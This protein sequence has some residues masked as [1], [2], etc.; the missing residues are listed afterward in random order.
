MSINKKHAPLTCMTPVLPMCE[1][2]TLTLSILDF[3]PE[4]FA[5]KIT[6]S[7][8]DPPRGRKISKKKVLAI[9]ENRRRAEFTT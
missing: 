2:L 5:K 3:G 9:T 8:T 1:S 6:N 7:Y 4:D